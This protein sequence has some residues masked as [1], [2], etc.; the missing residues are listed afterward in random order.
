MRDLNFKVFNPSTHIFLKY[1]L[2]GSKHFTMSVGRGGGE[3]LK[4]ITCL[5]ILLFL[6]S[7][8]IDHFFGW[9]CVGWEGGGVADVII[10]WSLILKLSLIKNDNF[11]FGVSIIVKQPS[12]LLNTCTFK[13]KS[14]L[15]YFYFSRMALKHVQLQTIIQA[16]ITMGKK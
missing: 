12:L 14:I 9:G 10:L 13:M 1:F 3:V 7:R 6:N 4:F 8:S 15:K 11:S 2:K 16:N 5:H